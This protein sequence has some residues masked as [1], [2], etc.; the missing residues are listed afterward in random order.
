MSENSLDI[1]DGRLS[2][3]ERRVVHL[4]ESISTIGRNQAGMQS[5][6]N[7]VN[8]TLSQ[9]SGRINEPNNT[10]WFGVISATVAVVAIMGAGVVMKVN[11]IDNR[12]H[13]NSM[14]IKAQT[15]VLADRGAAITGATILIDNLTDQL[16]HLDEQHHV[17]QEK[18]SELEKR[19][20]ASQVSR[21]AIGDYVKT[22]DIEG[23]R[24]S[25]A[26]RPKN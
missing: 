22:M 17:T 12:T 11:P 6:L 5:T 24:A 18:V 10:N 25:I 13:M 19:S 9:L 21:R 2:A 7:S 3:V 23:T 1:H 16:K 26:D 8:D 4:D 15:Q 14:D 20:A